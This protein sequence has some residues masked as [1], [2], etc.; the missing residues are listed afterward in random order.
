M[1]RLNIKQEYLSRWASSSRRLNL[2][3]MI[4]LKYQNGLDCC[5][6]LFFLPFRSPFHEEYSI[7]YSLFWIIFTIHLLIIWTLTWVLVPSATFPSSLWREII[8]YSGS[9][10]NAYSLLSHE[11]WVPL[12]KFMVGPTIHVRGRS[13]HLWYSEST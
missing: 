7:L 5:I 12:I 2:C 9:T 4:A 1:W 6:T 10:I 11:W 8:V 3:M 13:T